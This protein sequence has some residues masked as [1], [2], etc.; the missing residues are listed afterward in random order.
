MRRGLPERAGAPM[1]CGLQGLVPHLWGSCVHPGRPFE[2]LLG[3]CAEECP[4]IPNL[5]PLVRMEALPPGQETPS[6]LPEVGLGAGVSELLLVGGQSTAPLSLY[7]SP[8]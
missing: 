6:W 4:E 3:H 1:G 8:V 2:K 5:P 7:V